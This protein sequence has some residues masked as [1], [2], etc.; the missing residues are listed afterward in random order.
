MLSKLRNQVIA[1][2]SGSVFLNQSH[3]LDNVLYIPNFTFN[4]LSLV[5]WLI[6]YRVWLHL[7]VLVVT[8]KTR[9]LWKWLVQLRCNIDFIYSGS[10]L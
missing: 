3:V 8:F 10:F 2:Y 7:T 1:N 6:I 5:N 4:L 9:T